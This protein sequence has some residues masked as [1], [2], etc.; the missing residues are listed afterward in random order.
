[1]RSIVVTSEP[2]DIV[3]LF[4]NNKYSIRASYDTD[5]PSTGKLK[6]QIISLA[7]QPAGEKNVVAPLVIELLWTIT[8]LLLYYYNLV[9]YI[10]TT[11]YS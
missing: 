9:L 2:F 6:Y 7:R 5:I 4:W 1:M 3:C 11:S 8:F 10:T